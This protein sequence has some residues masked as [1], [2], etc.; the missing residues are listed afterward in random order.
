MP[1][2]MQYDGI[3]GNVTSEF[4]KFSHDISILP[5]PGAA[6][7]VAAVRKRHPLGVDAILVG[8]LPVPGYRFVAMEN[9]II[10]ILIGL[11]LPAVQKLAEGS[12]PDLV[13]LKGALKPQAGGLNF[14]M[15]DGSVRTASSSKPHESLSLNYEKIRW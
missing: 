6:E 2:Y 9:G 7:L 15:A 11:L 1:I 5:Y 12:S 13:L 3:K 14:V 8:L 4:R 10:A